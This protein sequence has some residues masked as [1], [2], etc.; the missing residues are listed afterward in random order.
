MKE[1]TK[2]KI[3]AIELVFLL[4]LTIMVGYI[5]YNK[6][7]N[8]PSQPFKDITKHKNYKEEKV[9]SLTENITKMILQ[10]KE[11][12][13]SNYLKKIVAF[14]PHPTRSIT[15]MKLYNYIYSEFINIGLQV[16]YQSWTKCWVPFLKTSLIWGG[17]YKGKNIE[18][19]L[20]G[21]NKNSDEIYM[22][23]CHYD[24]WKHSQG[25]DDD[26]T[27]VAMILT[28]AKIISQ[29]TFNHT[30]CFV[31][32]SGEEQG[33]FGSSTYVEECYKQNKNIVACLDIEQFGNTKT[34]KGFNTM[35]IIDNKDSNWIT[36]LV[37][38]I[39]Q[40]YFDYI[41]LKVF[42][43]EWKKNYLSDFFSFWDWGYN[44][45]CCFEY[46]LSDYKHSRKDTIE[47]VNI[48]YLLKGTK[49]MLATLILFAWGGKI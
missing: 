48:P 14:G 5:A 35:Q 39:S 40:N 44:S 38:N 19:T 34:E 42:S 3:I 29:Y 46:E 21:K 12:I 15:C 24:T 45:I 43:R 20:P 2:K 33:L 47:H 30:I 8:I 37:I 11:S 32:F 17:P 31:L 1:T 16:K 13:L 10:T 18:A 4:L 6:F 41:H 36:H 26:S 22:I 25:A 49:L 7:Q 27:G 23:C 28:I 9:Y